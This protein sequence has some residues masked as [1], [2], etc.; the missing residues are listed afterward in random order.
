MA[1]ETDEV[2]RSIGLELVT[3][4]A[5]EELPLYPSLAAESNAPRGAGGRGSSEDQL[6][7]FG[8]G[9]A[10]VLLTPVI[11]SFTRS[12]WQA[13]LDETAHAALDGVLRRL[14]A[15]RTGHQHGAE[16]PPPLTAEQL[17]LVRTVAE[18]EAHQLDIPDRQAGL[19]ADAMVGVLTT[20][21]VS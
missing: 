19:L 8:A 6:L 5:P 7:G 12:F 11:L 1:G 21:P 2:V 3:R 16:D 14:R 13:L 15:I 18:R 20:A 4:L 9:E 17:R 10:M